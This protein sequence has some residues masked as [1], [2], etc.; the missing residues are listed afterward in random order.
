[1]TFSNFFSLGRW[2]TNKEVSLCCQGNTLASK[3]PFVIS[4]TERYMKGERH[5]SPFTTKQRH[6]AWYWQHA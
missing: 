1:M 3:N 6:S 2:D 4:H 5:C